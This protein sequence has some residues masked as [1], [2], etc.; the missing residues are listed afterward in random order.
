MFSASDT[1]KI[2]WIKEKERALDIAIQSFYMIG[3][4][5]SYFQK[6]GIDFEIKNHLAFHSGKLYYD[7]REIQAAKEHL[8]NQKDLVLWA[9]EY[10][11]AFRS[12]AE[13]Y[14]NSL[15]EKGS[16]DFSSYSRGELEDWYQSHIDAV[17]TL[18]PYS[19]I[20]SMILENVV[21]DRIVSYLQ[22]RSTDAEGL[23]RSL[24]VPKK[25]SL[26]NLEYGERLKLA[27]LYE[28][29][30]DDFLKDDRGAIRAYLEEFSWLNYYKPVD[31]VL[32]GET[33]IPILQKTLATE[34]KEEESHASDATEQA[35]SKAAGLLSEL[36]LPPADRSLI[37]VMQEN[38]WLRTFRR[39]L[40]SY[41]FYTS[42]HFYD[43]AAQ[44]LGLRRDDFRH[45]ACWEVLEMLQ[46]GS[47]MNMAEIER[48]KQDFTIVEYE[49]ELVI[50]SGG[51]AKAYTVP[52]VA[53]MTIDDLRGNPVFPGKVTGP[54]KI[55][56]NQVDARTFQA[57]DILVAPTVAVWMTSLVQA[58]SGIIT[59]EGGVLSH[60]AVVAREFRKPCIVGTRYA[61]ELL[62]NGMNILL[63]ADTGSVSKSS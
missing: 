53:S 16:T 2:P 62:Q 17:C 26:M 42:R 4:S 39:E 43:V 13:K 21:H 35:Y 34:S 63:N 29:N 51:D 50:A 56:R 22:S 6:F 46:A 11:N 7:Q 27:H 20:V 61:T 57:G 9:Q 5:R 45:V 33:L 15:H 55:V 47:F 24:I 37:E 32:D 49:G 48:R 41:S 1:K 25:N 3:Q 28:K 14:H 40:M 10:T 12:F 58:S 8:L 30:G 60:T 44:L 38:A 23:Y 31:T 18:V 54:V 36:D 52:G 19:F 59:D